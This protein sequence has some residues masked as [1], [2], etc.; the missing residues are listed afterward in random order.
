M[1]SK[2]KMQVTGH[3]KQKWALIILSDVILKN[4]DNPKFGHIFLVKDEIQLL[5]WPSFL[6]GVILNGRRALI[7]VTPYQSHTLYF[8]P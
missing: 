4:A 6:L 8:S 3:H 2:V 7:L 5:L 1:Y